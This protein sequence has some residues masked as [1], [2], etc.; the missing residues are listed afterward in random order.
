MGAELDL[1]Y[2]NYL[3]KV[4]YLE[5]NK[6]LG[7]GIFGMKGGPSDDPCHDRFADD[8]S[9]L[10]GRLAESNPKPAE[11]QDAL[12]KIYFE[13]KK[14]VNLRSAYWMLL[15]VHSMTFDLIG[16]L[17]GEAAGELLREYCKEYPRWERLPVQKKVIEG[18]KKQSST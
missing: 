15:A 13:P 17:S 4:D 16:L 18:L 1:L 3:D 11:V 8:L 5:K 2:E 7:A 14:H 12:R 10:L 9:V 6:P